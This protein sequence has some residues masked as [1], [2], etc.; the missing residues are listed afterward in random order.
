MGPRRGSVDAPRA[1]TAAQRSVGAPHGE[2]AFE[3]A[4]GS[5]DV[6]H[7]SCYKCNRCNCQC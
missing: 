6:A 2:A 1:G 4:A 3:V 5:Y 7:A